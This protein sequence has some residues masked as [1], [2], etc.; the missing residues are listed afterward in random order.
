MEVILIVL[1]FPI[2]IFVF[3]TFFC[4]ILYFKRKQSGHD[5][6]TC[7][8]ATAPLFHSIPKI[9]IL[10]TTKECSDTNVVSLKQSGTR[11]ISTDRQIPELHPWHD[12]SAFNSSNQLPTLQMCGQS[13]E[14]IYPWTHKYCLDDEFYDN[15]C[16]T[17]CSN[18]NT[19]QYVQMLEEHNQQSTFHTTECPR[20]PVAFT[21]SLFARAFV[22]SASGTPVEMVITANPFPASSVGS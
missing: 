12:Y 8:E 11:E 18:G 19:H 9:Q 4:L 2:I 22:C 13:G 7:V 17:E 3:V 10:P 20:D 1:I 15:R 5:A 6:K 16:I 21:L 14:M